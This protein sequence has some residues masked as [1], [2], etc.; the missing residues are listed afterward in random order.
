MALP[1][2]A[3]N[4]ATALRSAISQ[5]MARENVNE[6]TRTALAYLAVL[7]AAAPDISVQDAYGAINAAFAAAR[8]ATR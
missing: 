5:M 1:D 2:E 6:E 8:K 4:T 3:M 7:A